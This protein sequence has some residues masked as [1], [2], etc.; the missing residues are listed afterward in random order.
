MYLHMSI[1]R[2][3]LAAFLLAVI[4]WS[5]CN[6]L[7]VTVDS[8]FTINIDQKITRLISGTRVVT[9]RDR[10]ELQPRNTSYFHLPPDM[11]IQA[12]ISLSRSHANIFYGQ[13]QAMYLYKPDEINV[14]T[15]FLKYG[16]HR[17]FLQNGGP[18]AAVRRGEDWH[19]FFKGCQMAARWKA[20]RWGP[21]T[22]M[23]ELGIPCHLDAAWR[24]YEGDGSSVLLRGNQIWY[25]HANDSVTGPVA[26]DTVYRILSWDLKPYDGP[27]E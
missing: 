11:K 2:F 21:P 25:W 18:D 1:A 8:G 22:S 17:K 13:D 3:L 10:Y 20:T 26:F 5:P 24:N 23:Q 6:G 4:F 14:R 12:A 7:T 15:R 27:E 9:I 16:R 19:V